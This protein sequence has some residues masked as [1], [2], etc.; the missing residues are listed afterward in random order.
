MI[1]ASSGPA[2]GAEL[3]RDGRPD[4]LRGRW[5]DLGGSTS[6]LANLVKSELR[7][8]FS[9]GR[10]PAVADFLDELP[11][12]RE[13]PERMLSLIYEEFCLCEEAGGNPSPESF[14]DRYADWRDSLASQLNYHRMLSQA[15]GILPGSGT[16]FP[17]PGEHF[18]RFHLRSVLGQGGA[19]R[20]FLADDEDLGGRLSALKVSPDRGEEPSIM[21]RLQHPH[22]MPVH[23]VVRDPESGLRGLCMPYRPGRPLDQVI[24]RMENLPALAR[25]AR[26]LLDAAAPEDLAARID[27]PGW[28][29][30]PRRGTYPEACAWLTLTLADALAHSHALGILHRDVK[31][32]N[33]LLSAAD[34]PQLLDFNLAHDPHAPE[35]AESAL[36]G[37]TLPYMAPEQL[38][39]FRDP[40]RWDLVGPTAD[41]YALGLVLR[42]LLTG[43]RPEAPAADMPLP[44]AINDLLGMRSDGWAPARL[45]NPSVPHALEAILSRCTS[46]EPAARY[47]SAIDL[48]EDLR[49]FL[50]NRPLVH[51]HNP[52]RRERTRNWYRRNRIWLAGLGLLAVIPP[53]VRQSTRETAGDAGGYITRGKIQSVQAV[54][55]STPQASR[56]TLLAGARRDFSRALELDPSHPRAIFG[57]GVV[58]S[59][60][61]NFPRAVDLLS[62]AIELA[63]GDEAFRP[64]TLDQ[65]AEFWLSA[66]HALSAEPSQTLHLIPEAIRLAQGERRV[67]Y[68]QLADM[69]T[70]RAEAVLRRYRADKPQQLAALERARQDLEHANRLLSIRPVRIEGKYRRAEREILYDKIRYW[71]ARERM[72]RALLDRNAMK[73]HLLEQARALLE[74]A[75]RS[76]NLDQMAYY[77]VQGLHK[78]LMRLLGDSVGQG[79]EDSP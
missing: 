25:T 2:T 60:Q 12:L 28:Q 21:G 10:R 75:V 23:T 4:D 58:A 44:R 61:G 65:I 3:R 22:I 6:A 36:R 11:E 14:C 8:R 79:V 73:R 37:G 16:R 67:D 24:R 62:Q 39:A 46:H 27:G 50:R 40:D 64:S 77:G 43:R 52:S 56:A 71:G 7:R 49:A 78:N 48:A 5:R 63:E 31:P 76:G 9:E 54:E 15:A 53:V 47:A 68:V 38:E 59:I 34:G 45:L 29:G 13:D 32:A 26:T 74:P 57:L 42:E 17:E 66:T 69:Y 41:C 18:L 33:V 51:A 35:R 20:V 19:A 70:Y 55:A 1:D 72:G 30:F